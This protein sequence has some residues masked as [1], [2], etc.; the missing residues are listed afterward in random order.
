MKIKNLYK[1]FNFLISIEIKKK[2]YSFLFISF[3]FLFF[4]LFSFSLLIPFFSS[5][6]DVNL[7]NE[8]NF[9]KK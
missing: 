1:S 6:I 8:L 2:I 9:I 4:N 3:L 5:L 7:I